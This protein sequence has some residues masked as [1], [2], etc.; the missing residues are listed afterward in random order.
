MDDE[1]PDDAPPW[2]TEFYGMS[3]AE[4]KDELKA[5]LDDEV[6]ELMATVG[7][8]I[9]TDENTVGEYGQCKFAG[10]IETIKQ[11]D[12]TV[13]LTLLVIML[14]AFGE[15]WNIDEKK[16]LAALYGGVKEHQNA[17]V[18]VE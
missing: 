10:D 13:Q 6:F 15:A 17:D 7:I 4:Q 9:D 12:P 1:I 2:A 8:S 5:M 11:V 3:F 14:D 18:D 16:I